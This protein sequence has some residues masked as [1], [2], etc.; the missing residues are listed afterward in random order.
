MT[1]EVY[2][3]LIVLAITQWRAHQATWRASHLNA[4]DPQEWSDVEAL[5]TLDARADVLIAK[6]TALEAKYQG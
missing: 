6:A 3:K 2:V 5:L 1:P 4:A